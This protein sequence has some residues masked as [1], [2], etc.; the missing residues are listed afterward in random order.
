MSTNNAINLKAAGIAVYDGAGTFTA[1]TVTQHAVLFGG[2]SNAITSQLLT[3]GQ[4]PIGNT[5]NDPTAAALTAGTG[6]SITNGAGS[7]TI[8]GT[9]GG[10]TWT[11]VTGTTQ[12]AAVNNGYIANNAGLVTVTL[13]TTAAVGDIVAVTGINNAT[14]WK[15]AQSSGQQVFF[16]TSSTTSGATGFLASTNTRDTVFLLC[17]VANTTFNVLD[18]IGNITVS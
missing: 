12:T 16:G 10:L 5:G 13:P 1:D 14:G 17:V 7:I 18:S 6:I 3:N 4:L 2:A 8:A 9:G 15:I 11:V